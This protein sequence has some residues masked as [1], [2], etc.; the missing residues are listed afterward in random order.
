M[1]DKETPQKWVLAERRPNL[2]VLSF[3]M[4]GN[5]QLKTKLK[6]I[7]S[8]NVLRPRKKIKNVSSH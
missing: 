7:N 4:P 8:A 2:D 3:V 6:T 1:F 5:G